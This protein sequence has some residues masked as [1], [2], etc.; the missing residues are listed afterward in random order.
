VKVH[1]LEL[2][3][4][5]VA[6]QRTVVT[7]SGNKL[8]SG[9]EQSKLAMP[10]ASEATLTKSV[11][12]PPGS[13]VRRVIFVLQV[14]CGGIVSTTVTVNVQLGNPVSTQSTLLTPKGKPVPEGGKHIS[15]LMC[16]ML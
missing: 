13:G 6:S 12:A 10:Q 7:P 14:T 9:G 5:S 11:I 8:P 3:L 15:G 4:V 2:P 1:P 16:S